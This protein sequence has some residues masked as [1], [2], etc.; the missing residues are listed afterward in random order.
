MSKDFATA[1]L[2]LGYLISKPEIIDNIKH[3][4]IAGGQKATTVTTQ[5]I[6]RALRLSKAKNKT[7][8]QKEETNKDTNFI[9]T[10]GIFNGVKTSVNSSLNFLLT[11][12]ASFN[13]KT[14]SNKTLKPYVYEVTECIDEFRALFV[15]F[16][17]K[18]PNDSNDF[19][20]WADSVNDKYDEIF[21]K[22]TTL[23]GVIEIDEKSLSISNIKKDVDDFKKLTSV[24]IDGLNSCLELADASNYKIIG[25]KSAITGLKV[26]V[27]TQVPFVWWNVAQ[28]NMKLNKLIS[29]DKKGNNFLPLTVSFKKI[30]EIYGNTY[31]YE[32]LLTKKADT[33]ITLEEAEDLRATFGNISGNVQE[34]IEHYQKL[35]KDALGKYN[36]EIEEIQNSAAGE[37][38]ETTKMIKTTL[39]SSDGTKKY[40][41]KTRTNGEVAKVNK[42]LVFIEKYTGNNGEEIKDFDANAK[43]KLEKIINSASKTKPISSDFIIDEENKIEVCELCQYGQVSND[44]ELGKKYKSLKDLKN[45]YDSWKSKYDSENNSDIKKRIADQLNSIKANI[46]SV[47]KSILKI[48]E[49]IITKVKEIETS[50]QLSEIFYADN[51]YKENEAG[52]EAIK[53]LGE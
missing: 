35:Y 21:K 4:I 45:N 40:D 12:F 25:Y 37:L 44:S 39:R 48:N 9:R 11:G 7:E 18:D 22:I 36:K 24:A 27:G 43:T 10:K 42:N 46:N 14:G 20:K 49:Q 47:Q 3:L 31:D 52:V 15:M 34:Y 53:K 50:K 33:N 2:R 38:S 5:R 16:D 19:S 41:P 13:S 29:E 28:Y 6:G 17:K 30:W 26:A 32:L 51:E 1:G 23:W 8:K